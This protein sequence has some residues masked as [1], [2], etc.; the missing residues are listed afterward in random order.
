MKNDVLQL[1]KDSKKYGWSDEELAEYISNTFFNNMEGIKYRIMDA[2]EEV[3][4]K[5][6]D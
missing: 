3:F 1:I 5:R 4:L 6:I 2:V